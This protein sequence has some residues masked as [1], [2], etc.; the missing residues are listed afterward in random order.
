MNR[1]EKIIRTIPHKDSHR[2]FQR[3]YCRCWYNQGR[4]YNYRPHRNHLY[5]QRLH[6]DLA[7]NQL[8]SEIILNNQNPLKTLIV[9]CEIIFTNAM[10]SF[11]NPRKKL[12]TPSTIYTTEWIGACTA[13]L[14]FAQMI[15]KNAL[16][17]KSIDN[18]TFTILWT[19]TSPTSQV[20]NSNSYT[21]SYN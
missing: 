9:T 15:L 12:T 14:T 7:N 3:K 10:T 16:S 20:D 19:R 6:T 1:S 21:S 17:F 18:L 5:K 11:I 8:L 4:R 2:M 13:Q